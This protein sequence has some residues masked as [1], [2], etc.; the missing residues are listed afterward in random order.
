MAPGPCDDLKA[1]AAEPALAHSDLLLRLVGQTIDHGIAEGVPPKVELE[2][3]PE[4]LCDQRATFVTLEKDGRLRG[5]IGT[6]QAHRPLVVDLVEN[7]FRAAFR[8]PRF[9]PVTRDERPALTLS[10]SLLSDPAPMRFTDE[11]DLKAQLVPGD[12]GLIIQDGGKRSTFLPQVWDQLPDADQFLGRLKQ[13]AGMA[14]D[15]WS[16]SFQAWRYRVRKIG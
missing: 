11:A 16:D 4:T 7:A 5:C 9:S 13:K 6:L 3:F 12:D 2:S 8:D 1:E 15:H 14:P 10:I